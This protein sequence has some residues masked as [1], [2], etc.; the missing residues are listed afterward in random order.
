ME[1]GRLVSICQRKKVLFGP[2]GLFVCYCLLSDAFWN[3]SSYLE[4]V[5]WPSSPI[6][7]RMIKTANRSVKDRSS[8]PIALLPWSPSLPLHPYSGLRQTTVFLKSMRKIYVPI[9]NVGSSLSEIVY[10][11]KAKLSL[12]T[13]L[14]WRKELGGRNQILKKLK[15]KQLLQNQKKIIRK[16]FIW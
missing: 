9:Y 11:K 4:S 16:I 12:K 5:H 1:N 13:N 15:I 2:Y 3:I 7:L 10:I 14:M 6:Y 8:F